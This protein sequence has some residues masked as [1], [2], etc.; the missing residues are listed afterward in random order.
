MS[1]EDTDLYVKHTARALEGVGGGGSV[2]A[3]V[4]VRM[5]PCRW[6]R[7][8][9]ARESLPSSKGSSL[10]FCTIFSRCPCGCTPRKETKSPQPPMA[11]SFGSKTRNEWSRAAASVESCKRC[12]TSSLLCP[13]P[14]ARR[15]FKYAS[16]RPC[17]A[18]SVND[19]R[20]NASF[21]G[22]HNRLP[23]RL[24]CIRGGYFGPKGSLPRARV[25]TG[26]VL[27]KTGHLG[28]FGRLGRG[29]EHAEGKSV[30]GFSEPRCPECADVP[31]RSP[32]KENASRGIY[33]GN[34]F[35]DT[36]IHPSDQTREGSA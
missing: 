10:G 9:R 14:G 27:A 35:V 7:A 25:E 18:G 29:A 13:L 19:E 3:R 32:V 16:C 23:I 34:S 33:L 31:T 24:V 11:W 17:T 21:E 26:G 6:A 4:C 36:V 5:V 1:Y 2:N 30:P 20:G 15:R 12:S 22:A 8:W 28:G